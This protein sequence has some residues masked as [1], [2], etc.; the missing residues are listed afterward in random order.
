MRIS[1]ETCE[2]GSPEPHRLLRIEGGRES[3]AI[4][5]LAQGRMAH[6][7]A[8]EFGMATQTPEEKAA[9]E[10]EIAACGLPEQLPPIAIEVVGSQEPVPELSDD[11]LRIMAETLS[12]HPSEYH[13]EM[14]ALGVNLGL[15]SPSN[16]EKILAMAKEMAATTTEAPATPTDVN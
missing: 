12:K 13:Q 11:L 5:S 9:T 10:A 1:V 2:C 6:A 4:F 3:K 8:L 14:V 7:E 15:M 16:G